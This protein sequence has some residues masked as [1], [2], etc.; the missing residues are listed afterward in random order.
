MKILLTIHQFLPEYSTGSEILTLDVAKELQKLG[1]KVSIFTGFPAGDDLND[2]ERFDSYCYDGI[3]VT[4]YHH[5]RV[6]VGRHHNIVEAEYNNHFF[7][8]YFRNY[9]KKLQ[10]DLVHFFH[11]QRLS[12][13]A[14]NVC[15]ELDIP[16]VMTPT[17]FWLVCP[18]NQLKLPDNSLCS[19]PDQQRVN[20]LRHFVART[21]SSATVSLFEKLPDS[22]LGRIIFW[23]KKGMFS[24]MW[25]SPLVRALY[26][27]PSFIEKQ[28]NRLDRMI[29]PTKLME[30]TLIRHGLMSEKVVFSPYGINFYKLQQKKTSEGSSLLRIGF[31]GTLSEPKG[32][33]VLVEAIRLIPQ[34][35][36]IKVKLYGKLDDFPSYVE[37]LIDIS[38]RD[39]RIEFCGTFPN[40]EIG[41]VFEDIDV[42]V[43]PSIW[44]ENTPLVIY[45]A[46]AACCPVIASD[47]DGIAEAVHHG[48]NGLLFPPGNASALANLIRSLLQNPA[49]LK[50]LEKNARVPKSMSTYATE[51]VAIYDEIAKE[52]RN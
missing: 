12:A 39:P 49:V 34:E 1:H 48:D 51:L 35:T 19:G 9:L 3:S 43:V 4:R 18:M 37:K 44:Y 32:A 24:C 2:H 14:I 31:I 29:V 26:E 38:N 47:L 17:D 16:M 25:F 23:I 6:S 8:S 40:N 30:R 21:Q 7:A 13:S 10:P 36:S 42:L 20:C 52:D 33:H 5:G 27:R 28:M 11:L 41:K 45:S 15:H 50:K 22:V 46:Q